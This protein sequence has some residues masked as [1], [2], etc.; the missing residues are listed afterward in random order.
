MFPECSL[1]VPGR[2]VVDTHLDPALYKAALDV[3][4]RDAHH[5]LGGALQVAVEALEGLAAHLVVDVKRLQL[6]ARPE[7]PPVP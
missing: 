3:G 6:H 1:N 5:G 4:H 7:S 2:L